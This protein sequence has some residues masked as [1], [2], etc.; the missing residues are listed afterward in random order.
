MKSAL[1]ITAT[2]LFCLGSSISSIAPAWADSPTANLE[3]DV[4][5]ETED[6]SLSNSSSADSLLVKPRSIEVESDPD[7]NALDDVANQINQVIESDSEEFLPEGM[8]VRGSSGS[9]Q[10]GSEI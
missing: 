3:N 4:V 7:A 5:T 6:A 2:T 9:L 8:V 1:L 10:V